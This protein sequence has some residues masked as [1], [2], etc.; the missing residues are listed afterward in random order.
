[1]EEESEQQPKIRSDEPPPPRNGF[2]HPIYPKQTPE[3]STPSQPLYSWEL[4]PWEAREHL[5]SKKGRNPVFV[6]IGVFLII[7]FALEIPIA[8]LFFYYGSTDGLD[9]GGNITLSGNVQGEDGTNLSGATISI[10]GTNL[11]TTSDEKGKY[12]LENAPRGIWS[13]RVFHVGYKEETRRILI[14]QGFIDSLDF[15]LEEGVGNRKQNDLWYFF[16]LAILMLLFSP[17]VVAGSYYAFKRRRFAV[18]LVGA[19]LGIL[20]MTPSFVFE[21][22]LLVFILGSLGFIL[23]ISA[24]MMI[25]MNRR[26][27]LEREYKIISEE[28]D[29]S[30]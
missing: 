30:I 29:K 15:K 8:G 23:S 9:F 10:I 20:T 4:L 21:F 2:T 19:I 3:S 7:I 6:I 18:V 12:T 5:R 25:V 24:L 16:S 14:Q 28:E 26:A 13:V 11:T 22:S 27:F 17:F 1:M